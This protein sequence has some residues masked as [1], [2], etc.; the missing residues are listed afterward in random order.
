MAPRAGMISMTLVFLCACFAT[1]QGQERAGLPTTPTH[2]PKLG[3]TVGPAVGKRV[4]RGTPAPARDDGASGRAPCPAG[5]WKDDP[6]CFGA[7]DKDALPL[8]S[9]AST[10]RERPAPGLEIRPT[11]RLNP[12]PTGPGGAAY[13]S[14]IIY[15]PSGAA[16]TST[17]GGGVS[18]QLPF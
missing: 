14:E 2:E 5:Q 8:P 7:N 10:P 11:A 15:Q 6:V 17:Y 4:L 13:Q 1:A 3:P 9:S 12:R 18:V 16:V